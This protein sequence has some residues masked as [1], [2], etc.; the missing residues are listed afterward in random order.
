MNSKIK[1]IHVS[2]KTLAIVTLLLAL[3]V[4]LSAFSYAWFRHTI[5]M[6]GVDLSTG[7]VAYRFTG[8]QTYGEN[9][10]LKKNFAYSTREEDFENSF[11]FETQEGYYPIGV[12]SY[13]NVNIPQSPVLGQST[14]I[15]DSENLTPNVT[16]DKNGVFYYM[17]E[18]LDESIDLDVSLCFMPQIS[19]LRVAGGFW[20]RV[21]L[22]TSEDYIENPNDAFSGISNNKVESLSNIRTTTYT[23]SLNST[24]KYWY[25]RLTFGI[26]DRAES[27][28]YIDQ[29]ISITPTL[30]VAQKGGLKDAVNNVERPV[31]TLEAFERELDNYG[32]NDTI[33]IKGPIEY[34]GDLIINRPLNLR[35]ESST[36]TI[37]GDLRYN[38]TGIGSF[39]VD[40]SLSGKISVVVNTAINSGGNIH[41]DI[42]GSSISFIGKG[43][44]DIEVQ[45][46]F[47]ASVGYHIDGVDDEGKEMQYGLVIDK[48]R[49]VHT[50]TD[51][52]TIRLKDMS[53]L[54]VKKYSSI[55]EVRVSNNAPLYQ[56]KIKNEGT[57]QRLDLAQMAS[58]NP[59]ESID[60]LNILIENLNNIASPI[61]LPQW[62]TPVTKEI[63]NGNT[64]IIMHMGA[65]ETTVAENNNCAYKNEHI[66]LESKEL[67]VEMDVNDPKKI[68]LY[69]M[70][71][72]A[73]NEGN[74]VTS[75]G[76]ILTKY[77]EADDNTKIPALDQITHLTV[78]CNNEVMTDADY[79]FIRTE[80][81]NLIYL[82][83]EDAVS[84]NNAV[85][86]KA[87]EGLTNL[88]SVDMPF[89]DTKWGANIFNNTLVDEISIPVTV[90]DVTA[91][92]FYKT[93]LDGTTGYIR[94]I[95]VQG[96]S[97]LSL[98][99]NSLIFVPNEATAK[100]Y[101]GN[102][103]NVF[104]K[105]DRFD[106]DYGTFFLRLNVSGC[107]F[108]VWDNLNGNWMD[109]FTSNTF[110]EVTVDKVN[111]KYYEIDM[112]T[113]KVGATLTYDIESI[114][115]YAFYNT[116]SSNGT[117]FNGTESRYVLK[118]GD[119]MTRIGQYAFNNCGDIF[120]IYADN[121]SHC[122][123]MAIA[124]CSELYHL[125][126]PSLV[127]IGEADSTEA[128]ISSCTKL[129]W[130]K[131]GVINRNHTNTKCVNFTEK[132]TNIALFMID[133]P[134]EGSY[135]AISAPAING[136]SRM[137]L[138]IS[139][140]YLSH[141]SGYKVAMM[142]STSNEL[143]YSPAIVDGDVFTVPKFIS[144]NDTLIMITDNTLEADK[145][146]ENFPTN[147]T[148]IG[149]HSFE[150]LSITS[151]SNPK[152]V[153]KIPDRVTQIEGSAFNSGVANGYSGLSKTYHTLDLNNVVNMKDYAFYKNTM[154]DVN[155]PN[156]V[157]IGAYAL[158]E[159]SMYRLNLPE[160]RY[161]YPKPSYATYPAYFYACKNLKYANLGPLDNLGTQDTWAFWKCSSL[162]FV[163]IDG[164]RRGAG[165]IKIKELGWWNDDTA[166]FIAIVSGKESVISHTS[167]SKAEYELLVDSL[168]DLL[169][170]DFVTSEITLSGLTDYISMPTAI[171]NNNG[172]GT[173]TYR[174][175]TKSSVPSDFIMPSTIHTTGETVSF[176]G[177]EVNLYA[178]DTG[179][180]STQI[181]Y[182]NEINIG[183]FS[184]VRFDNCKKVTI[185][186]HVKT[187]GHSTFAGCS[188]E[189]F[190][191]SNVEVI[192]ESAFSGAK[193]KKITAEHVKTIGEKAFY[194]CTNL[195]KIELPAFEVSYG[196]SSGSFGLSG[197]QYIKLGP[198]TKN[199]GK[200]IFYGCK[201]LNT[202]FIESATA[203]VANDPF[204]SKG[205][206]CNPLNI[207]MIVREQA[208]YL[209]DGATNWNGVPADNF[210]YYDNSSTYK[211]IMYYWDVVDGTR[212]AK[213]T[214]TQLTDDWMT[215]NTDTL[216]IPST[217]IVPISDAL[218]RI[219][220]LFTRFATYLENQNVTYEGYLAELDL[221]EGYTDQD[222]LDA[223]VNDSKSEWVTLRA[224]LLSVLIS[225]DTTLEEEDN[226]ITED[227]ALV[228]ID[229]VM[230]LM[231]EPCEQTAEAAKSVGTYT[232]VYV[233]GDTIK[234]IANVF[235]FK[236]LQLPY[237]LRTLDF[238]YDS[239]PDTLE[240]FSYDPS[241]PEGT[242]FYF[243]I[244]SHGVLYNRDGTI[245]LIYP[246]GSANESYTVA[247]SVKMVSSSAFRNAF[248]LKTVEFNGDITLSSN[249][250]DSCQ[251]L[252]NVIFKSDTPSVFAGYS[253]FYNCGNLEKIYVPVGK[254]DDYKAMVI[255]DRV[256]IEN[257]L[258]ESPAE[259][260]GDQSQPS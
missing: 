224:Y 187:I 231:K 49:I 117:R 17:V 142:A 103:G 83:L 56:V 120:A 107:E 125:F 149:A 12:D 32:P 61:N 46:N 136:R 86:A 68:T 39:S 38:Y 191:L 76:T 80:M 238:S 255:F 128:I 197:L 203:P 106:T 201:S 81:E 57:I 42:P 121:V 175:Y 232:I 97:L 45:G 135:S 157:R 27:L 105:A 21:D 37:K 137:R 227:E 90:E 33:V 100:K 253:I 247:D 161:S 55:G 242:S 43:V 166:K 172:V 179:D 36:L 65:S 183:A 150:F 58:Q 131:T 94:Y 9:N 1:K 178:L 210:E 171:F 239:V 152:S 123:S 260:S 7:Q 164:E 14:I 91:N 258:A 124:N 18:R 256:V 113:I 233:S 59:S 44:N 162:A 173:Y 82:N 237:G 127:S 206:E 51:L 155:G 53:S 23:S 79:L 16:K 6:T 73:Q 20:Y 156:L 40:T 41:I 198:N 28:D 168:G 194:Q 10:E 250:F 109:A 241:A 221:V 99:T 114:G 217:V 70:K 244:D 219:S 147:V 108:V 87:F 132:S 3:I 104:I 216:M 54:Y 249:S 154:I 2:K 202:I 234:S 24:N 192:G 5:T 48:A 248:F 207:T 186:K 47:T 8:Y 196:S 134:S 130:V 195:T 240:A 84:E 148:T 139:D 215:E 89:S 93:N 63:T 182:V 160:L 213:I 62:S 208:D 112:S 218:P 159:T 170:V 188:A 88:R 50:N 96:D 72:Q 138:I 140:Q 209:V 71:T 236:N 189:E 29:N 116:S 15:S 259:G 226:V 185:P 60:G 193:L 11:K 180:S 78:I 26:Q 177:E 110:R 95:Y 199:L 141:Y 230:V 252:S 31:T 77:A 167:S 158:A 118:F 251:S 75:V 220:R 101:T 165:S 115:N 212:E 246:K 169:Y 211:G 163:V 144:Y 25:I 34:V 66:I 223:F 214:G 126:M 205:G 145:V 30:C 129:N 181:G 4:A 22:V 133:P 146:F 67:L 200:C 254:L 98:G 35:V 69:Y 245:L 184:N 119:K 64:K 52:K 74:E 92:T 243:T 19:N 235:S 102:K 85:P 204:Y 225:E 153:L 151:A 229:N 257:Y 111:F 190:D 143:S 174:K 122:G 222:I 176:L 13:G 228:M